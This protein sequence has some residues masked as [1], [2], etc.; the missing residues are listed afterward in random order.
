MEDL[1]TDFSRG[2][3]ED[4]NLK[5]YRKFTVNKEGVFQMKF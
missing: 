5:L 2:E 1:L 4:V 3:L